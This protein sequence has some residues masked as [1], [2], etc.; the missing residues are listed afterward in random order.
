MFLAMMFMFMLATLHNSKL[1]PRSE[2]SSRGR[3]IRSY[4]VRKV[5]NLFRLLQGYVWF[6]DAPGGPAAYYNNIARWDHVFKGTIYVTQAIIGDGLAV[7][8]QYF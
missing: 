7:R 2:D 6:R 8:H 4:S 3:T 1:L 5:L